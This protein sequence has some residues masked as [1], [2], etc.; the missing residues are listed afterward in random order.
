MLEDMEIVYTKNSS[1]LAKLISKELSFP[2]F[3]AN[4]RRFNNDEISVS[5]PKTFYDVI[6]VATSVIND[7]WIELF[8]LLDALRD[9]KNIILCMPYFG[10]SR[11][12]TQNKNES[13][14]AR[15]FFRILEMMSVSRCIILDNHNEPTIRIPY[16]HLS[17]NN[18]FEIDIMNKYEMSTIVVVSPDI[19]GSHRADAISRALKCDFAICNK[20]RNVF[21]ELKKVDVIGNVENKICV[22]IDDIIDSGA[23]MCRAAEAL[24]KAGSKGVVAYAIHGVF[25]NGSVGK[26]EKSDISEIVVTDSICNR[27]VISPKIRKLSIAPMIAGTIRD[28]RA[29]L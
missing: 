12:D 1:E 10:Y 14:G 9:A 17:A 18:L 19:G 20:A 27:N 22:L 16:I 7:D 26:I 8:L 28:I 6:V 21:G 13:F 15:L 4:V 25:S 2:L 23:T 3:L 5:V 24:T 29:L 11:Q